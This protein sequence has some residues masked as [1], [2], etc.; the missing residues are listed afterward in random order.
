MGGRQQLGTRGGIWR[1]STEVNL[2]VKHAWLIQPMAHVH[3]M[4]TLEKPGLWLAVLGAARVS[5]PLTG[6]L[7][8]DQGR[9]NSF[10][11]LWCFPPLIF[12]L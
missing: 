10:P 1:V 2:Q 7:K 5:L 9:E 8:M 11:F 3:G 4:Q 12:W 6:W